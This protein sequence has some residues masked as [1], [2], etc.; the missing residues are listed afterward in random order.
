MVPYTATIRRFVAMKIL[1]KNSRTLP[2]RGAGLLSAALRQT[3][4]GSFAGLATR[5]FSSSRKISTSLFEER[6][7]SIDL[8][9]GAV[10]PSMSRA[11]EV[12]VRDIES[13]FPRPS[14]TIRQRAVE[15]DVTNPAQTREQ[16]REYFHATFDKCEQLF[17]ILKGEAPHY[18]KSEPLRHPP[19]FYLGHTACF[20]INKLLLTKVIKDRVNPKIE[21]MCAVGVDEMSWDDLNTDH[22]DWPSIAEVMEYR[23]QVRDVVDNLIVTMPMPEN[24]R[25]G[26]DSDW[27]P[28]LMGI[29]HDNI[30]LETSSAIFR[31]VDLEHIQ[32]DSAVWPLC[33]AQE[34]QPPQNELVDIPASKVDFKKLKE[35]ARYYGWDNEFGTKQVPVNAHRASKYLVSNEEFLEF[36]QDGGYHEK[37]WWT[38]EGWT[39]VSFETEG[40]LSGKPKD[41]PRWWVPPESAATA[42]GFAV[43]KDQ[44]KLRCLQEEIPIPWSWPACVNNLEAKAFCNWKSAKLGKSLRLPSEPEWFAWRQMGGAGYGDADQ[45]DWALNKAPGNINLDHFASECPVDMFPWGDSGLYDV[46]GNVWQHTES[47]ID[48]FPGY[49]V[50]RLYDDFSSP[51]FDGLHA[52]IKGGSWISVG[53][54]GATKDSR[55][56]F[57]RHFYQHAGFRYVESEEHVDQTMT[58]METDDNVSRELDAHYTIPEVWSGLQPF[59][60]QTADFV[61][62]ALAKIHAEGTSDAKGADEAVRAMGLRFGQIG[63]SVGRTCFELTDLFAETI[64]FDQTARRLQHAVRLQNGAAAR[65]VTPKDGDIQDFHS[66]T[67]EKL[68]LDTEAARTTTHFNQADACNIDVYKN[69]TFDVV[70]AA[71]V[72]EELYA[73]AEFLKALHTMTNPG[74]VVILSTTGDWNAEITPKENWIGGYK[75]A[76]SGENV[77]TVDQIEELLS[78]HFE[79]VLD[80]VCVPCV[81]T[82]SAQTYTVRNAR[83]TVWR[84]KELACYCEQVYTVSGTKEGG[85]PAMTMKKA[86]NPGTN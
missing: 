1:R 48:A 37:K 22:Y 63:C 55:Y 15:L 85:T 34:S 28:I 82:Q 65:F 19:I 29:E 50:H 11:E 78:D 2:T 5:A 76:T 53:C 14:P 41:Y 66:I 47:P 84:R 71:N 70:L 35:N 13:S 44:W 16:V 69:G 12:P 42:F 20:Y 73:P 83:F 80:D 24:G 51:T 46:V 3:N 36:V 64:G 74:A 21:H 26:W 52:L 39:W 43:P 68:G 60:V 32:P 33:P 6:A 79:R 9:I 56:A 8:R 61:R 59:A 17:S 10:A 49:E 4:E 67:L 75:C 7:E 31:Q 25:L 23:K 81:S 18:I 62:Q 45:P 40:G 86:L 54:N 57:R 77:H 27:W 38:D 58:V 72:L 30:H